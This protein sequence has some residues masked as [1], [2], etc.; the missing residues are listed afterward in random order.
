M[1]QIIGNVEPQRFEVVFVETRYQ[2]IELTA[3]MIL[4]GSAVH[5]KGLGWS[6]VSLRKPLMAALEIDDR[7]ENPAF[8]AAPGQL[9][10][11]AIDGIEP[12]GRGRREMKDKP[13][14]PGEPGAHL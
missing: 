13:Q 11:E 5:T 8:E 1:R 9:G 6:L 12:G 10:E 3:A 2:W 4:S 7:A 14:V